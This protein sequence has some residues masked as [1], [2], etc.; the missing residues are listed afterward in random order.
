[1]KRI[2]VGVDGSKLSQ[3]ALE[4]AIAEARL[5]G[6]RLHLITAWDYPPVTAGMEGTLD[7]SEIESGAKRLQATVLERCPH[8]EVEVTTEVAHGGAA[9]ILI[10]ASTNADLVVV[11]SRGHGG[12]AGLLLGS[13]SN[14]VVHHAACSVVVVRGPVR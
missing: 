3:R 1:M 13:V 4:W 14:Q 11:G 5:R 2:I 10:D 7:V 12:F 9:R 6:A 8:D